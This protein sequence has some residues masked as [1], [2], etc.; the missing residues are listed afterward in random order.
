M[1]LHLSTVIVGLLIAGQTV[2]TNSLSEKYTEQIR[3]AEETGNRIYEK[4]QL[5]A[6]ATDALFEAVDVD[7]GPPVQG[8]VTVQRG[9]DWLVRFITTASGEHRAA[10]DVH[11]DVDGAVT[12][13][14]R[15][16][17]QP[18][19]KYEVAMFRARQSAL[20]AI[21]F[22]CTEKLNTVVLP[23]TDGNGWIIY[24]LSSTTVAGE[25]VVGGHFKATVSQDG[26]EVI[27]MEK[28]ANTC[29]TLNSREGAK[30]QGEGETV[31]AFVTHD[32]SDTPNET[33]VFLSRVHHI[34][35]FVI[36]KTGI[37]IVGDGTIRYESPH[38][39]EDEITPEAGG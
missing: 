32:L 26:S 24:V 38:P 36:T 28:L 20:E 37:W 35:L 10:Y 29:L 7:T 30:S 33:H 3:E 4:D 8:W 2:S 1:S 22:Q 6:R 31:G 14:V 16:P 25:M 5:A 23:S 18:L 27:K 19:E 11:L 15:S 9:D 21:P 34:P 12:V 13:E 39:E 17:P